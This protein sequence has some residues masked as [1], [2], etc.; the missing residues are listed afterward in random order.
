MPHT[1][2][3]ENHASL[4]PNKTRPPGSASTKARSSRPCSKHAW[5]LQKASSPATLS[6]PCFLHVYS[7]DGARGRSLAAAAAR[8][9]GARGGGRQHRACL[10]VCACMHLCVVE[11]EGVLQDILNIGK[12]FSL[13]PSLSL[14]LSLSF[15]LSLSNQAHRCR[16]SLSLSVSLCLSLCVSRSLARSLALSRALSRALSCALSLGIHLVSVLLCLVTSSAVILAC[17]PLLH[18]RQQHSAPAGC[19]RV[20]C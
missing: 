13:P 18:A 7:R 10:C 11:K 5:G 1:C 4:S 12:S 20:I 17:E 8:S 16:K 3:P 14:S 15:S 2:A 6:A 19:S 9:R